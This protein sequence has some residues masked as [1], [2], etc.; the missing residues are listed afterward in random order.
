[1]MLDDVGCHFDPT[2]K[3]LRDLAGVA[4]KLTGLSPGFSAEDDYELAEGL[5][6]KVEVWDNKARRRA[7][8][9][10]SADHFGVC[11]EESIYDDI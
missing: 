8:S 3:P 9:A 1:M 5:R 4:G 7:G 10:G 11:F 6:K 2:S